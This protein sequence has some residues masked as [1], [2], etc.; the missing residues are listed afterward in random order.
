MKNYTYV[1][2][3]MTFAGKRYEVRGKTE[4]EAK[5]KLKAL[6][7]TL[8]RGDFFSTGSVSVNQWY[9]KWVK[10][11][12]ASSGITPKSLHLYDEKYNKYLRPAIGRLPLKDIRDF[13]LQEILN[14]QSGMSFSHVSKLRMVMQE[15]FR[16]AKR[17]RLLVYD[18]SEGL[19]LPSSVKRTHRPITELER[20]HI[21]AV[22]AEHAAGLWVL[23]LLY[24]G[25][26]PVCGLAKLLR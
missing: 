10:T 19:I 1:R 18:P 6:R 16:Q 8:V 7:Q 15:M 9:K 17:S 21:L 24:A 22:A 20:A 13:H 5:E 4:A 26:R 11:Y 2:K 3:T 14:E 12:K 25:L 23:T